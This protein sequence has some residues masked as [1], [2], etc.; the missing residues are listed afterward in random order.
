MP[1]I[2]RTNYIGGGQAVVQRYLGKLPMVDA[3]SDIRLYVEECDCVIA[4]RKSPSTCVLAQSARRLLGCDRVLVW[5]RRA[6][7]DLP[8]ENGTRAI[9]RFSL[10]KAATDML[11][12]F[13]KGD[14]P[15]FGQ[16]IVLKAPCKSQTLDD[17]LAK[18]RRRKS[19]N[20]EKYAEQRRTSLKKRKAAGINNVTAEVRSGSGGIQ[21]TIKP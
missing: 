16:L 4:D 8:Q 5:R 9:E 19:E 2:N 18:N 1:K 10:S 3:K 11:S 13:D 15:T 17:R 6:Y 7:L 20:P 14:K 12:N 21:A